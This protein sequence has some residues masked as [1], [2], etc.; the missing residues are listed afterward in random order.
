MKCL[1]HIAFALARV[2]FV[3]S[4]RAFGAVESMRPPDYLSGSG[5]V[6]QDSGIEV[7]VLGRCATRYIYCVN[8]TMQF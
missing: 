4:S 3:V 7:M 5:Q 8:R 1:L 2:V 6:D